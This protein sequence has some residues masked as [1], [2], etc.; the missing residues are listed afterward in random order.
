MCEHIVHPEHWAGDAGDVVA[1][2]APLRTKGYERLAK[3][4]Q[5]SPM[6]L[7]SDVRLPVG[8]PCGHVGGFVED[9]AADLEGLRPGADVSPV[10]DCL[11]GGAHQLGYLVGGHV[12]RHRSFPS[13]SGL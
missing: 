9:A 5:A 7:G 13:F 1:A 3:L 12:C 4:Q 10:A 8:E 6:S 2:L 11:G